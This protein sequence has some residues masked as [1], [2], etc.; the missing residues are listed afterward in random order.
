MKI[1]N[2]IT[3]DHSNR[4]GAF[5][6]ENL[7]SVSACLRDDLL[8]TDTQLK[9]DTQTHTHTYT[10]THTRARVVILFHVPQQ[11][12]IQLVRQVRSYRL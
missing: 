6:L 9:T 10:Y 1:L 8:F 5:L 4:G 12:P 7:I 11:L 2:W 3:K